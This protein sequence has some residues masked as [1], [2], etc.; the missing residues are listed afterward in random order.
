MTC[1]RNRHIEFALFL[2]KGRS[3]QQTQINPTFHDSDVKFKSNKKMFG[4]G[5]GYYESRS[6]FDWNKKSFNSTFY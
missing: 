5:P 6:Y 4:I 3:G 1:L 2:F